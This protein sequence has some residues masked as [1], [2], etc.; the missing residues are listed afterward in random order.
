MSGD[1]LT[2]FTVIPS[3]AEGSLTPIQRKDPASV[4]LS[5]LLILA[6]Y[7]YSNFLIVFLCLWPALHPNNFR[8]KLICDI[9]IFL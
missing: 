2:I 4:N 6:F 1:K 9:C 7:F 3:V 5:Y 8:K